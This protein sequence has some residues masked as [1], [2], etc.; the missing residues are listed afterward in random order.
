M[1]SIKTEYEILK[2]IKLDRVKLAFDM[3]NS[4]IHN[5]FSWA[6]ECLMLLIFHYF[7][8]ILWTNTNTGHVTAFFL[9]VYWWYDWFWKIWRSS[10]T[11][12]SLKDFWK[13]LFFS[14]VMQSIRVVWIFPKCLLNNFCKIIKELALVSPCWEIFSFQ[15]IALWKI[16]SFSHPTMHVLLYMGELEKHFF[17][18]Q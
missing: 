12:C 17:S 5:Y 7:Y 9:L 3:L 8:V 11:F 2:R 14:L 15:R 6:F 16:L 18:L 4:G 13:H 10:S 1:R